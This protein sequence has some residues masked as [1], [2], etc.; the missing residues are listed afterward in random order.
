[1]ERVS[2]MP[3]PEKA[4]MAMA[5]SIAKR[6]AKRFRNHRLEELALHLAES[7]ALLESLEMGLPGPRLKMVNAEKS[8]CPVCQGSR[9]ITIYDRDGKPRRIDCPECRPQPPISNAQQEAEE[10]RRALSERAA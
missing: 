5:V 2:G 3:P 10:R 9:Q 1:M 4:D 6:T 8:G 7:T